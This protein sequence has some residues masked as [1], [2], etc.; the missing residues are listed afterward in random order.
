MKYKPSVTITLYLGAGKRG[1]R[2]RKNL[3]IAAGKDKSIARYILEILQQNRPDLFN[4][5]NPKEE[6]RGYAKLDNILKEEIR[7]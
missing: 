5:L 1:L 6:L 7:G 2:I 3:G 4:D